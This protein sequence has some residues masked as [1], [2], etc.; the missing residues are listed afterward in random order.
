ML[1]FQNYAIQ[2]RIFLHQIKSLGKKILFTLS[3]QV[4]EPSNGKINILL[5]YNHMWIKLIQAYTMTTQS[6]R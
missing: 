1:I 6:I 2:L 5:N 3:P 4:Q